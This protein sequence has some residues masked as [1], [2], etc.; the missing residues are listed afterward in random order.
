M[1]LAI[2]NSHILESV[3]QQNNLRIRQNFVLEIL[4]VMTNAVKNKA[5][6]LM[7][8]KKNSMMRRKR[9]LKNT[10]RLVI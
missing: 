6:I 7:L 2:R 10:K 4:Q 3:Y 8:K 1:R 9:Q 5:A